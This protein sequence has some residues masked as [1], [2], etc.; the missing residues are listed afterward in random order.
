ML[1]ER[2]WLK[3]VEVINDYF[4]NIYYICD[5]NKKK[6]KMKITRSSNYKLFLHVR[7]NDNARDLN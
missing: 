4:N 1:L 3:S 7:L 2:S 6:C 5:S